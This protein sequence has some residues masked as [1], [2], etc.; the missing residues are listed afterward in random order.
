MVQTSVSASMF[1]SG[2][3]WFTLLGRGVSDFS[4]HKSCACVLII[5][6]A[7]GGLSIQVGMWLRL[8]S[9]CK[10]QGWKKK[11]SL[12]TITLTFSIV[13]PFWGCLLASVI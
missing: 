2:V 12:K 8:G 6:G 4:G 13:V 7:V 11:Q 10:A 1:F 3:H 9:P 5:I